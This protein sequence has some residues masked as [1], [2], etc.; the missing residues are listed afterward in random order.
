MLSTLST[1]QAAKT[2]YCLDVLLAI[3]KFGFPNWPVTREQSPTSLKTGGGTTSIATFEP[4]VT[5][6]KHVFASRQS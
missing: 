4:C 1:S 6:A 2:V 3:Q 5:R